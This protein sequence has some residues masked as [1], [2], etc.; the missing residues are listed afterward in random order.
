M[1]TEDALLKKAGKFEADTLLVIYDRFS[2]EIF[3]Y[4]YRLLGDGDMAEDCV[5][6]T[7]LRF[8]HAIKN[9]SGPKENIRAYLYRIAH[10]WITDQYRKKVPILIEYSENSVSETSG[11]LEDRVEHRFKMNQLRSAILE[12]NPDQRFVITLRYVEGW[13]LGQ[14]AHAMKRP[15][16]AVKALQHRALSNLS[17]RLG[18]KEVNHESK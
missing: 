13:D 11:H 18:A 4:A 15:I 10:N 3:G 9:N 6:E 12:L 1:L 14:I 8:I 16:G 5:S 17:K 7:F 2:P